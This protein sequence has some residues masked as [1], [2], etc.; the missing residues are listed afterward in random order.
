M[1]FYEIVFELIKIYGL[2]CIWVEL[3]WGNLLDIKIN[4]R[5]NK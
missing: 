3:K 5:V 1:E 4:T 2:F